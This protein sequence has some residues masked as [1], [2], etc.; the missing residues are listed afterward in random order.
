MKMRWV[1]I[2]RSIKLPKESIAHSLHDLGVG[3]DC[4]G[5]TKSI[6][7]LTNHIF[8]SSGQDAGVG[9]NASLPHTMKRRITI[10]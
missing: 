6:V 3:K 5:R 4:L 10:N 1:N 2:Y 9:R 7:I 8:Q